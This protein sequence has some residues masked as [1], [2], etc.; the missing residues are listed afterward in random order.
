MTLEILSFQLARTNAND[1]KSISGR[2]QHQIA[3]QGSALS[4]GNA[5]KT[6]NPL[7]E[8]T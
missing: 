2:E 8:H 5:V 1:S 3:A 7:E 6:A 4:S